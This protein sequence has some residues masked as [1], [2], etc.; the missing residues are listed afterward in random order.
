MDLGVREIFVQILTL[1]LNSKASL[2]ESL[3]LPEARA[4]KTWG[5]VKE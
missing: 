3:N 4:G 1:L 2:D 5:P